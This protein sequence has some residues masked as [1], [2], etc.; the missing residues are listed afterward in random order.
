M[1][2]SGIHL[3]LQTLKKIEKEKIEKGSYSK[4]KQ[5]EKQATYCKKI[6]KE[7]ACIN[8]EDQAIN[9][10]NCVR[11]FNPWPIAWTT[12][13]KKRLRIFKTQTL[14]QTL[15]QTSPQTLIETHLLEKL[16]SISQESTEA[17]AGQIYINKKGKKFHLFIQCQSVCKNSANANSVDFLEILEVQYDNAVKCHV[18]DFLNGRG[19]YL[20]PTQSQFSWENELIWDTGFICI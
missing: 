7:E 12:L 14:L 8:W 2:E 9:I 15:S 16:Q 13:Q 1:L 4:T 6:T 18:H 17:K 10:H 5:I 11:A 19:R 20:L 3:M